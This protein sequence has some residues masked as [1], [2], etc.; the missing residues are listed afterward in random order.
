MAL[1]AFIVVTCSSNEVVGNVISYF[2]I[3]L[4]V[5]MLLIMTNPLTIYFLFF[6]MTSKSWVVLIRNFFLKI[7]SFN[8]ALLFGQV[9]RITCTHFDGATL[10]QVSGRYFV[11]D[12]LFINPTGKFH[13]GDPYKAPGPFYVFVNMIYNMCIYWVI[14]WYLDHI[15]ANNRGRTHSLLFFLKPSYYFSKCR[16]KT[17]IVPIHKRTRRHSS[18][19]QY[20]GHSS[21]NLS[22]AQT[23]NE[24]KN[25]ILEDERLGIE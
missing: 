1:I 24:E 12:D 4:S 20:E 7:P 16:N 25:Q 14:I 22:L 9:S 15:M 23:V 6:N 21:H 10:T 11:W 18:V 17:D 8:F 2:V 19:D 5:L 13:T 3:L